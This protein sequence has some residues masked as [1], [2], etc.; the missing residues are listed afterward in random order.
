MKMSDLIEVLQPNTMSL[1]EHVTRIS[2]ALGRV[3]SSIFELVVAIKSAHDEL[4]GSVFQN[5]LADRLGMNKST[6]SRWLQIGNSP[7]L[8]QKQDQLPAT[9]S[10]LYDLARLEKKYV[11]QYG[12]TDGERR[13]GKLIDS[14]R[15]GP[16]SE[17]ADI[18][19]LLKDIDEKVQKQRKKSRESNINELG[20][21]EVVPPEETTTASLTELI[22]A[23]SL[24][25]T[26]VVIPPSEILS[27]WCN[28]GVFENDIYDEFPL[29]DL[30]APSIS[31][32]VECLVA[33]PAHR[34]DVGIKILSAFGFSY[35]DILVPTL[36]EKGMSLIRS[37]RVILRGERGASRTPVRTEI[38][39]T[40]LNDVLE[41]S[42]DIGLEPRLLVFDGTERSGWVCLLNR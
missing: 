37:E 1:D 29:A 13:F 20:G 22:Q 23:G 30:R 41:F 28:D 10:S 16:L 25:R 15:V 24:F 9:F 38:P 36:G 8:K 35:R 18:Q 40:S 14:G 34:V 5:E 4:G 7:S 26:F 33:V 3:R 17:Q 31:E 21:K 27:R 6:L 32:T 2:S 12:P 11:D 19:A 39:S 42:E